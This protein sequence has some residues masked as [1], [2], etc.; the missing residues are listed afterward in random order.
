V[1]KVLCVLIVAALLGLPS[2][3]AAAG[4][5][6]AVSRIGDRLEE[7]MRG[8]SWHRGCPV[9]IRALRHAYVSYHDFNGDRQLGR[10]VGHRDAMEALRIGFRSMWRHDFKLR[11]VRLADAYGGERPTDDARRRDLCLQLPLRL[12]N[13]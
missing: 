4:F 1:R 5:S 6:W 8:V 13:E 12:G 3:V 9:P 11:R 7:R 2:P 10:I